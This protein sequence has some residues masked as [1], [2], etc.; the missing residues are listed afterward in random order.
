MSISSGIIG[1]DII[2]CLHAKEIGCKLTTKTVGE[3]F[4]KLTFK[5]NSAIKI[6]SFQLIASYNSRK[7]DFLR[8]LEVTWN[9]TS[10]F[11]LRYTHY[12]CFQ[13]KECARERNLLCTMSLNCSKEMYH[14]ATNFRSLTEDSFCIRLSID[15]L[16]DND[17]T[18]IIG[19][20]IDLLVILTGLS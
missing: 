7:W 11:S 1:N 13:K 5:R 8:K 15:K 19:E 14:L 10:N 12:C 18:E 4:S 6:D 2:N 16:N 17:S 3:N 9:T 20:A